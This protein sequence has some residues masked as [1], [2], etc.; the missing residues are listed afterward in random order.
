MTIH[1]VA[2][3]IVNF[4]HP[5]QVSFGQAL[6]MFSLTITIIMI[7]YALKLTFVNFKRRRRKIN[8]ARRNHKSTR[9][10]KH[11]VK[12]Y[13]HY[14]KCFRSTIVCSASAVLISVQYC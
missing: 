14:Q 13:V 12:F 8:N 11:N 3:A 6:P 5:E 10:Y 7:T 9:I 1:S 4:A 2:I